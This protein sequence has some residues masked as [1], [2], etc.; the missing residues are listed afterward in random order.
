VKKRLGRPP[1]YKDKKRLNLWLSAVEYDWLKAQ[2]RATG[3]SMTVL[4]RRSLHKAA[5][6]PKVDAED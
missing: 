5:G 3:V 4:A 2:A 6:M 1:V